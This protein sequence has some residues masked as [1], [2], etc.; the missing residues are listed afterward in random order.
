MAVGA[1]P[2]S[3]RERQR[4][5]RERLI[6]QAAADL[7]VEQGYHETSMEQIAA[8][9]GI[10]KWT[11][12]LHFRSKEELVVA[13]IE[14][15]VRASQRTIEATLGADDSP[16]ARLQAV[17]QQVYGNMSGWHMQLMATILQ[18]P[19]MRRQLAERRETLVELWQGMR[20]QIA[21]LIDEGKAAG[22]FDAT[23]PTPIMVMLFFN[24]LTPR[25]YQQLIVQQGMPVAEVVQH[26]SRCFFHGIASGEAREAP[27]E[28]GSG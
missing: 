3:L 10:A 1:G 25:G 5:E 20:R 2:R 14:R 16:R 18:S 24:L 6:L 17:I 12:Y 27:Q 28:S 19:E 26:V 15:E 9:V 22:E 21:V 8:R 23:V 11:V 7:L 13:L 4:E